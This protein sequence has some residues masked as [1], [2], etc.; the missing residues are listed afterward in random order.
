MTFKP[1]LELAWDKHRAEYLKELRAW[2][3][4]RLEGKA[5]FFRTEF[6]AGMLRDVAGEIHRALQEKEELK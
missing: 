4:L 3:D 5:P 6:T 1:E 2:I